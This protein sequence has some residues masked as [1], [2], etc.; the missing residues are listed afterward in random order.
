MK[1]PNR[2]RNDILLIIVILVVASAALLL[3]FALLH[4]KGDTVVVTVDGEEYARLP[5]NKDTELT[6]ETEDGGYNLLVIK[7]GKASITEA[8]CPTQICVKSGYASELKTIVC[9]PHRVVVSIE[10]GE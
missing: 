9:S 8:D 6:I 4:D 1:K 5:L 3:S 10:A 2:K 7:D